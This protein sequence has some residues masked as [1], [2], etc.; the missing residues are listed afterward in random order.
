MKLELI[1]NVHFF[2]IL[3]Y[4]LYISLIYL[5]WFF[6]ECSTAELKKQI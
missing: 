4:N 3:K 1:A 6:K 5:S 2:L